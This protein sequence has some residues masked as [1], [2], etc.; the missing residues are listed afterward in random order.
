MK[1]KY[2]DNARILFT[3][4]DSL[5]YEIKTE[6]FY[7]DISGDVKNKFDT[8][9]YPSNHPS[10]IPTG[11]NKKVLGIMK[12][13]ADGE[14]IDEF[15]GLRAKLYSY[16]MLEGQESK[17]CKGVKSSVIN[18]SILHKDYKK[19]LFTKK[20]ECRSMKIFR[21]R[22]HEVYTE[23]VNKIALSSEDDKRIVQDNNTDTLAWGYREEKDKYEYSES[24]EENDDGD[25][26]ESEDDDDVDESE[27]E[28]NDDGDESDCEDDDDESESEEENDD[29]DESESE[30]DDD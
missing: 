8:S 18:K 11:I 7:K 5:M 3:D 12:D 17:K 27:S 19:C 14:I 30:D 25:E 29:G 26:S 6:D 22:L 15:V 23:E 28:E 2:G 10:G 20:P 1:P 4:K 13:K 21:S 16:K 24:E 9:N